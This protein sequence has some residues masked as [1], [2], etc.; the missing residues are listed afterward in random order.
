[1][2]LCSLSVKVLINVNKHTRLHVNIWAVEF[3]EALFTL[4]LSEGP[5]TRY[6]LICLIGHWP[7]YRR[8]CTCN[9]TICISNGT[10]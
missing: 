8:V 1:M 10:M 2:W 7:L 5:A 9:I 3:T 4:Q 6:Y